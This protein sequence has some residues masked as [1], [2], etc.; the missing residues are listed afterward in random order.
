MPVRPIRM[1]GDPVLRTPASPVDS[2]DAELRRLVRDL[3]DTM[4]AAPG[5]GLAAPQLGVSLRVLVY[6]VGSV[7]GHLVNPTLR[8]SDQTQLE[9]EG[10]LSIPGP[11]FPC[12]RAR[13]VVADGV[14]QYGEPVR[15]EGDGLLARCLQHEADHLDG[16]LFVDRLD[17][18]TRRAAMRAIL[19]ADSDGLPAPILRQ[20]PH[21]PLGRGM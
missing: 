16:V 21:P 15:V 19:E 14:D 11:P 3:T 17:R 10:C 12:T 7:V 8:C 5:T 1:F 13:R 20:S 4:R 6:H 9:E 18:E 2:F